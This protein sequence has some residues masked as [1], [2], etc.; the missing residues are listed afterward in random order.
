M[1]GRGTLTYTGLLAAV[2]ML[3]ML[4]CTI[5]PGDSERVKLAQGL[6][7]NEL[8]PRNRTG[9]L[10][11]NGK[12]ADWIEIKNTST[13]SLNLEG[14]KLALIRKTSPE[15][16]KADS[17]GADEES[18]WEFPDFT[19]AAGECIVIFADNGKSQGAED[20]TLS[21]DF[22]LPKEGA[23]LQLQAPNGD[24]IKEV[25]YGRLAPDQT[26]ALQNDSTYAPTYW[27]SPGFDNTQQGYEKAMIL[28]DG[29][30]TDPLRISEMMSR[31][32]NSG[33][34]WVELKNYSDREIDLSDYALSKKLG[35]DE[36]YWELPNQKLP[37]GRLITI[38]LAG[39]KGKSGD[40]LQ[41]PLKPGDS[42]TLV[43]SK[44]GDFVDG[45]CAK[46]TTR[47]GSIG[48]RDGQKGFFYYPTP[49]RNA[50]N[51][52]DGRRF[53]A[54]LPQFDRKPGVYSKESQ[55][56][57]HLKD[58]SRVVHY[59]LD[60]SVP[61]AASP[62]VGDSIVISRGTV[63]RTFAEGDSLNLRSNVATATYLPG[64][65]HDMAV[66]NVA[67]NHADLYDHNRGIYAN[68]PGYGED[69]PH[70]GANFWK[71]WT[72]NA[73]VE[74]FDGKDGFSTDCGLRIFGGY[75]RNEAKK[76]FRL[77]FRGVYGEEEVDY[78]F[79]GD[80]ERMG[81][82]DLVLRSGSQDYNRGMIRDEFF[83]SLMQPQSPTL[84]TQKYRP[85]A[86][87]INGD[88]FGLY[89]MREKIDKHFVARKLNVPTDSIDIVLSGKYAETG[90]K[91]GYTEL[92]GYVTS[93][94]L[95]DRNNYEYVKNR[96]DLQGLADFKLGE[97]Y[98]GNYDVG[99]IRYVRSTSS[100]GDGKW[101]F[102][103]FDLD[104]SW[105]GYKPPAEYYLSSNS[106]FGGD[107]VN[108]HNI[109]VN[110]LLRNQEFRA[111]FLQRLSHHL[112]HTF[113]P[114][115]ATSVFD[116][117]HAKIRTEMELNCQRWPQLS[118]KQ[119]GNNMVTFKKMLSDKPKVMLADLRKHLNITPQENKKYFSSLGY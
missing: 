92:M 118:Y 22:K 102:I 68:G 114:Q 84:L 89:Y 97:I 76:S 95:A 49:T 103:F 51:G 2:W 78:D 53:I 42:E 28:M 7:F 39:K 27:Q 18:M 3:T 101:H 29:Q 41:A 96:V 117:M 34:N 63:I 19:I 54:A 66:M 38:R 59:T 94:D 1:K 83:T 111:L 14:F 23:T 100:A 81:L 9:L 6:V 108:P 55:L 36:D 44:D 58:K 16:N 56:C 72:K 4:S 87:Y 35:K 77:K 113:S 99:N 32:V 112:T 25:K 61:T 115:N 70:A 57:L 50:P 88:Y 69:K 48:R 86:L 80:G 43:L 60:G 73:H 106:V 13:D 24:V 107:E 45:V 21:A 47:G 74:F 5:R 105:V 30:R 8:M 104:C 79:F 10:N 67:V 62:T 90:S 52:N 12:P 40:A 20:H 109:L 31:A 46:M 64:V 116:A 65:S 110:N 26:L 85:V 33:D 82:K 119:W 75:S 98:S 91:S 37:P 93:H 17:E 11:D 15:G 71:K